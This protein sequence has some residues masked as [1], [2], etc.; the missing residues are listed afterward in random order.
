[1]SMVE[2]KLPSERSLVS[3]APLKECGRKEVLTEK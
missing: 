2:H 3:S 1:M